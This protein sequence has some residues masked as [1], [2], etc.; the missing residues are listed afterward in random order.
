VWFWAHGDRGAEEEAEVDNDLAAFRQQVKEN[1]ATSGDDM[2][3][4]YS[5]GSLAGLGE[6]AGHCTPV[7]ACANVLRVPLVYVG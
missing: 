1:L 6:G 7:A 5:L 3:A 2:I 4:N